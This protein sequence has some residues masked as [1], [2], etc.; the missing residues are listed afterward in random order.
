MNLNS[1]SYIQIQIY[2]LVLRVGDEEK[3]F[4]AKRESGYAAVLR[5]EAKR[6]AKRPAPPS[7]NEYSV[8]NHLWA[9]ASNALRRGRISAV[10]TM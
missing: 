2:P 10:K 3:A 1:C 5:N 7:A 8:V 4:F 9:N 6:Q